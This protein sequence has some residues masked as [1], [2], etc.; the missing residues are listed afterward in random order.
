[1]ASLA[2]DSRQFGKPAGRRAAASMRAPRAPSAGSGRI[3]RIIADLAHADLVVDLGDS[4]GTARWW[5]GLATFTA[6]AGAA[7]SLGL[8]IPPITAAAPPRASDAVREE[9]R[10][11]TIAPLAL[12][13]ATGRATAPTAL[14]EQL[15][16]VPERPR[17]ELVAN[18]GAG[19]LEAALRRAGVGREDLNVLRAQPASIRNIRSG[20]RLDIAL[21]RRESRADPRPLETL[22][23]RASFDMRV[24]VA[25][26]DDGTLKVTRIPIAIDDTPLRVT[27][28]V[29]SSFARSARAAGLPQGVIAEYTRQMS[30]VLN[31]RRDVRSRDRFDIIVAHRRA[32]TGETQMGE[33]LYAGLRGKE[34]IELMRWG[35]RGNFYRANGEGAKRGLMQT[36]V[37]GARMSSG[38]GMRMHPVLGYSR[39]HRGVDFAARTGT[40][41]LAAASG[42]V[43]RSGWSGGYGNVVIVDHGKGVSTRYA[44]LSKLLVRAGERVEQGARIGLVGST[45]MSTGP[46]LHYEVWQNGK[47]VNPRQAQF[48]SGEQLSGRELASFKSEMNR[49]QRLKS[50]GDSGGMLADGKPED[51]EKRG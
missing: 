32:E 9:R 2:A 51:E 44:H 25:R 15:S 6:L 21:G 22:A 3:G 20:T 26:Q 34:N 14:V 11:D 37:S 39:M 47:P 10:A 36:P 4:I 1:M 45:G 13:G 31:F 49:L 35:R 8:S 48:Q 16:E 41:V 5:R 33:L 40:P 30:H 38:F 46:H 18:V 12:G 7:V 17:V 27:G 23:Y 42:R 24:E 19:G 29:G 28:T 50:A 43:T